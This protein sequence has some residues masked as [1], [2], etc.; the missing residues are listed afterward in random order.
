MPDDLKQFVEAVA[1]S[2]LR[3]EDDLGGGFVR[4]RVSEAERRQAKHDI[5]SSEDIVIE[6]LRNA[7]D[8]HADNIFLATTRSGDERSIVMLDDGDGMP[9]DMHERVFEAR[10]TSKLDS[11]KMDRWGVHGRGMALYSIKENCRSACVKASSPGLGSSVAVSA[12]I[13]DIAEKTDQ[14]SMPE[15]DSAA[16]GSLTVRGPRNINRTVI[17]FALAEKGRCSVYLGSPTEI[18]ATMFWLSRGESSLE[19]GEVDCSRLPVTSRLSVSRT[20]AQFQAVAASL[21]L[22]MSERSAR[23]VMDG[24]IP[25][26]PQALSLVEV[27]RHGR[28]KRA[29]GDPF[30]DAR[31]LKASAEDVEA[32]KEDLLRAWRSFASSYYLDC[33]VDPAVT[34]RKDSVH[35]SFPVHK[36]Q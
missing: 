1:G 19:G 32:F 34:V 10:V 23:R 8:A 3:V 26:A 16:D 12:H 35:V 21:G 28:A 18:A 15:L 36:M 4:L 24:G 27:K 11:M 14:S 13:G 17:E 20:P 33:D 2:H 30:A 29:A 22:E 5:R 25:P 9:E 7:R 31:G 6:M